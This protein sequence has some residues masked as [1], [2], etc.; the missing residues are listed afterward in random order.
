MGS[1]CPFVLVPTLWFILKRSFPSLMFSLWIYFIGS[2]GIPYQLLLCC[3][4]EAIL[5]RPP[6][7][8]RIFIPHHTV[9]VC[10]TCSQD[11]FEA[12]GCCWTW[13]FRWDLTNFIC[14]SFYHV[15][16]GRRWHAERIYINKCIQ[17]VEKNPIINLLPYLN[18]MFLHVSCL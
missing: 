18:V 7:K 9:P 15:N 2:N 14:W 11:I 12:E 4:K 10:Y 6:C 16:Y 8:G 17:Y 1:S 3:T 5:S 13:C